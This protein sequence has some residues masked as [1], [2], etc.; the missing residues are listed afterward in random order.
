MSTKQPYEYV[1]ELMDIVEIQGDL[2][3]YNKLVFEWVKTGKIS[4]RAFCDLQ[5]HVFNLLLYK[6]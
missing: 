4:R 2:P 3:K 1:Q 6:R 5:D